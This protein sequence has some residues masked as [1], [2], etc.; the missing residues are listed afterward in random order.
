MRITA[1]NPRGEK[2]VRST[3][4]AGRAAR[5]RAGR[6]R[7]ASLSRRRARIDFGGSGRRFGAARNGHSH[8]GQDLAAAEG[9][10]LV[11]PKAGTIPW[12]AYQSGGA[13]HYLVLDADGEDYNYVFMHLQPGSLLVRKGDRVAA[14][15]QIAKSA[16]P[17]AREGPHLHFEIWDG[18]WYDGGHPIDPLPFLKSW[19]S[20]LTPPLPSRLAAR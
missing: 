16:T 19:E 7:R 11:A 3:T 1:R 6:G 15:Q 12:R 18:P 4:V 5:S 14:G 8:Q 2:A 17:A 10:P 20:Q 13:G 9:T